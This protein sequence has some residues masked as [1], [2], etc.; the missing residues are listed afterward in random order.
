[1]YE[2]YK[3]LDLRRLNQKSTLHYSFRRITWRHRCALVG[4]PI[5]QQFMKRDDLCI[6]QHVYKPG[7]ITPTRQ[8]LLGTL[9]REQ[10]ELILKKMG[11]DPQSI[12]ETMRER[13]LF[14]F[15]SSIFTV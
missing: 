5:G 1:M 13:L 14:T 15:N 3:A 9:E 12:S 11:L 2:I 7:V 6:I 4:K 8:Q 10:Q